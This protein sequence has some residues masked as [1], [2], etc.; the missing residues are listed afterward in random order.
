[1]ATLRE[2]AERADVS[3]ATA[4]RV[5]NGN[6]SV[7]EELASRV[8][9]VAAEL[10]YQKQLLQ[11]GKRTIAVLLTFANRNISKIQVEQVFS[12]LFVHSIYVTAS[13]LGY[14]L[15][16]YFGS[17]SGEL[18]TTLHRQ[19]AMREFAGA[20]VVGNFAAMEDAYME[21]LTM[22]DIPFFCLSYSPSATGL[23]H[24]YVAVDD[25]RGGYKITKHLLDMGVRRIAHISGP[26]LSRDA[27]EREK[28]FKD[29]C[30]EYG[31]SDESIA[32]YPG[33]FGELSG[34]EST[35]KM[36]AKGNIPE[37]IFAAN[38]LMAIG[39]MRALKANGVN[40]PDDV[41]VVGFDDQ[42]VASYVEPGLT[43][44]RN[45]INEIAEL[46]T[47]GLID[48]IESPGRKTTQVLIDGDLIIRQSCG[49]HS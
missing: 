24:N 39:A 28:G 16:F 37:A 33:D 9:A 18:D 26:K 10:G 36:L 11:H 23:R 15:V 49:A 5:L 27:V 29:A 25:Y 42:I 38:D 22:A 20:L 34:E 4:S 41:R 43:T 30:R 45:P 32:Y 47:E 46:A 31:I 21:H 17:A 1:M 44:I 2:I 40:V 7:N 14:Q 13:R 3:L 35:K 12:M 8:I 6:P 48:E 19:I